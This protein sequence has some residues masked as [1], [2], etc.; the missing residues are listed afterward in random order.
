MI[1]VPPADANGSR[2][3]KFAI[4]GKSR[5]EDARLLGVDKGKVGVKL[6]MLPP[7]Y[8]AQPAGRRRAVL[9]PE[10]FGS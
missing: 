8:K 7:G 10:T 5:L 6:V 9:Q 1:E 3:A 4:S 2:N